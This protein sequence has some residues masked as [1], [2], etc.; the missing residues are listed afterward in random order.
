MAEERAASKGKAEKSTLSYNPM[1]EMW[2]EQNAGIGSTL[3]LGGP[4]RP[5]QRR[6]QK[7]D[8]KLSVAFFAFGYFLS[9]L[10][11]SLYRAY[12]ER[13]AGKKK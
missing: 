5:V 12:M 9:F 7:Y 8:P 10:G 3:T 1:R 4:A 13:Y 6:K 11:D 2:I